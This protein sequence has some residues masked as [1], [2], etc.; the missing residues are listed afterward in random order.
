MT[1]RRLVLKNFLCYGEDPSEL[2]F[3]QFHVAC[4]VG[5]NG[6]GKSS[7]LESIGW[8]VWGES[9]RGRNVDIIRLGADYA[10]VELEFELD[11]Q[12]YRIVRTARRTKDGATQ[13]LEFFCWDAHREQFVPLN[14][15]TI[16]ATQA[17]IS[18]VV[19]MSYDTFINSVFLLQGRSNE[20]TV[21][22]STKR[23]EVLA[24]ILQIGRYAEIAERAREKRRLCEKKETQLQTRVEMLERELAEEPRIS[25]DLV[26]A[27]ARLSELTLQKERLEAELSQHE[28]AIETLSQKK[29]ELAAEELRLRDVESRAKEH[30]IKI[31]E[32]EQESRALAEKLSKREQIEQDAKE[33]AKLKIDLDNLVTIAAEHQRLKE[34]LLYVQNEMRLARQRLEQAIDA[35]HQRIDALKKDEKRL[36]SELQCKQEAQKEYE[37]LMQRRKPLL[38]IASELP[39]LRRDAERLSKASGEMAGKIYACQQQMKEIETKGKA[40]KDLQAAVCPICQSALTAEHREKVLT[41]YREQYRALKNESE[42]LSQ[43]ERE[44]ALKIAQAKNIIAEKEK[45]E[46]ELKE[47]EKDLARVD[48]VIKNFE[49]SEKKLQETRQ[50]LAMSQQNAKSL[51]EQLQ[52]ESFATALSVQATS[53][54]NE[55]R[56]LAYNPDAHAALRKR[57][58]ALAN[59]PVEL[60]KIKTAAENLEKCA[61]DIAERKATLERLNGEKREL[62][63]KIERL[64]NEVAALKVLETEKAALQKNAADLNQKVMQETARAQFL[65]KRLSDFEQKREEAR[66]ARDATRANAEEIELYKDLEEAF[67][68][69][70]IQSVLIEEAVP[71][72]EQEANRILQNLTNNHLALRIETKR[73]QQN[74]KVVESLDIYISDA[75]GASRDYDTFSGGEKFRVDFALRVALA[76]LLAAQRNFG[77]KMLVIDE[78]FGSQDQEGLD[79]MLEAIDVVKDD[80]EKILIITHLDK[81]HEQFETKIFVSKDAVSG[82]RFEVVF[83]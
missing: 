64:K 26:A 62:Q 45:R 19:G 41:E 6:A 58:D 70:G 30:D 8:C 66:Q 56:A 16:R 27:R 13:T 46:A 28:K 65:E 72:I 21:Q 61:K 22:S 39:A 67:G 76:K 9:P 5:K 69:R 71:I 74:E 81:L 54:Q 17:K 77:L 60:E 20:F 57:F 68:V 55:L 79:A 29:V 35:E 7:L 1:P 73:Q 23:K 80:F 50:S 2:C 4:I 3:N 18:R 53:L 34:A 78:G 24:E 52:S 44:I 37:Q 11:E 10:Q 49:Q 31:A 14:G 75:S 25:D 59:A 40:F 33:H 63:D 36:L 38:G 15:G 51:C 83:N 32:R 42:S 82:A 47:I 43:Q 48:S 12:L